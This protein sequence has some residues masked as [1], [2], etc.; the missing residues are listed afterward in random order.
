M[1]E[2][3]GLMDIWSTFKRYKWIVILIILGVS[4]VLSWKNI[5]NIGKD[6]ESV[7]MINNADVKVSSASYYVEPLIEKGQGINDSKFYRL[8]PEDYI[9]FFNTDFFNRYVYDRITLAY[10]NSYIVSKINF[11]EGINISSNK[12]TPEN[13]KEI[14]FIKNIKDTMMI[15]MLCRSYDEK[16]S[17]DIMKICKDFII[18]EVDD[19]IS[20]ANLKFAGQ[21]RRSLSP[22]QAAM[23]DWKNEE[24]SSNIRTAPSK[25]TVFSVMKGILIP[26]IGVSALSIIVIILIAMFNP[27]LNRESD[28]C[29][30]DIP[31]IGEI[32]YC[33]R[34]IGGEK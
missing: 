30:Y 13:V 10:E 11:G 9:A 32:D 14:C 34:K 1:F 4:T 23:E 27:T 26:I 33:T 17:E 28:F 20:F 29:E 5:V 3:F 18:S 2:H 16:L 12:F 21:T 15:S 31:V 7:Y 24:E 8:I 25:G 19:K 6:T 22:A